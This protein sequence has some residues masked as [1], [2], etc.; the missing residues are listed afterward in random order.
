MY[1]L[2]NT[3]IAGIKFVEDQVFVLS[4]LLLFFSSAQSDENSL[5]EKSMI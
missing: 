1:A 4:G 3:N 2:T 5:K